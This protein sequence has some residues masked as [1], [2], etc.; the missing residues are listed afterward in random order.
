MRFQVLLLFG[1]SFI[2]GPASLVSAEE[3]S[4]RLTAAEKRGGFKLLFDGKS[5]DQWRGFKRQ[6]LPPSGWKIEEGTLTLEPVC[7]T[8]EK[9]GDIV[10]KAEYSNFEL[11][12][13]WRIPANSNSGVKYLVDE[14]LVK[15]G[16]GGLGFEMQI[17]DNQG[18]PDA[19]LG[20]SGNRTAIGL[21]DLI[22]PSGDFTR[23]VGQ[24]NEAR[25]IVNG[26]HIEH[27]LNGHKV[28]EFER[29][30]QMMKALIAY[31][32]YKDK[33][34]FGETGK[35]RILLQDHG[36]RVWFRNIRVKELR[37]R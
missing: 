28:V 17:L 20:V 5:L 32:K 11:R 34:G 31:S 1:L 27:W 9:P 22:A 25:L 30:C 21:Y 36:D 14:N 4:N 12:I 15:E 24:W 3:T 8:C 13:E 18:H 16:H 29:G 6:E 33:A 19:K 7:A 23:P 10:T 26:P 2:T 37:I 35:G